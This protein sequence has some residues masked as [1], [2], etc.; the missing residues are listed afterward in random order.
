MAI[1]QLLDK[2][3]DV[4]EEAWN[5]PFS[6]GKR[7][8]DI[9]RIRD[10]IDEV[11]MSIPQEIKDA[12]AIV[13]DREEILKDARAEAD[14]I[15][16][17]AEDKAR[18]MLSQDEIFKSAKEKSAQMLY[19]T[20]SKTREAEKAAIDY[21]ETALKK[22]EEALL[23]AYNEVKNT[24]LAL[25]NKGG[26]TQPQETP[27]SAQTKAQIQYQNQFQTQSSVKL[28]DNDSDYNK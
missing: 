28:F 9:E 21:S 17:R 22:S 27:Q 4:M 12:K 23:A 20:Q 3:D 14:S 7:M 2:I 6:G 24:R 13:T 11:R 26:H 25:R 10:L 1:D 16:K 8:I 18:T 19:E 5:L 15:V